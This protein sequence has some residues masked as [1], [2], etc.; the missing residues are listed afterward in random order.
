MFLGFFF[1]FW[2]ISAIHSPSSQVICNLATDYSL[3]NRLLQC[4]SPWF[5]QMSGTAVLSFDVQ[6]PNPWQEGEGGDGFPSLCLTA[7]PRSCFPESLCGD[8]LVVGGYHH[9]RMCSGEKAFLHLRK[10]RQLE[11]V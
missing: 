7:E 9:E 8:S 6:L 5:I 3:S 11:K 10:A 2:S 1:L 4:L